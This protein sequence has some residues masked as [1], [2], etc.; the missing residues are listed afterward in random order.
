MTYCVHGTKA[1]DADAG[2]ALCRLEPGVSQ[3][4]GHVANIGP[5]FEHE[6]GHAVTQEMATALLVDPGSDQAGSHLA[7]EP[8]RTDG[9]PDRREK[10]VMGILLADE[11]RPNGAEIEPQ[12]E[13]GTLTYRDVAILGS[14][15]ATNEHRPPVEVHV[16]DPQ[17]D[18]FVAAHAT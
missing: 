17:A 2:V 18:E 4:L 14:F 5:A 6:G 15:P 9:G 11:P 12:P 3:H 13:Q 10:Q 7:T 1:I 8:V 16:F